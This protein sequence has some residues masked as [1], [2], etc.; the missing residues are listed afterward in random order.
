MLNRRTT[1]YILL[2]SRVKSVSRLSLY[3]VFVQEVWSFA[4]NFENFAYQKD[5]LG[6]AYLVYSPL[7][8]LSI[9]E[10]LPSPLTSL[11]SYMSQIQATNFEL[12]WGFCQCSTC[13]LFFSLCSASDFL[14]NHSLIAVI[15]L[16]SLWKE[17]FSWPI[18]RK[19]KKSY[20]QSKIVKE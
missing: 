17:F 1:F 11:T 5:V 7:E 14:V 13:S 8:V 6:P 19:Q 15:W 16:R 9:W 10:G 18:K 3:H 2:S 20:I 12:E 4:H